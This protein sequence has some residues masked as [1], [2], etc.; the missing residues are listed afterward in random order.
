MKPSLSE[1]F[2][3]E[4]ESKLHDKSNCFVV[5]FM[6]ETKFKIFFVSIHFIEKFIIYHSFLN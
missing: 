4:M 3:L 1:S 6:A 2:A 5:F